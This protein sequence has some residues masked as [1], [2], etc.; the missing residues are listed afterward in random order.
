MALTAKDQADLDTVEAQCRAALAP[1][2][3]TRAWGEGA[4]L[5][6][7]VVADWALRPWEETD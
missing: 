3:F 2:A 7:N 4:A 1:D 5:D 6:A